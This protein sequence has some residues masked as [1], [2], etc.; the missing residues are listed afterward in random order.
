MPEPG[1]VGTVALLEVREDCCV[2]TRRAR[3]LLPRPR[4]RAAPLLVGSFAEPRVRA[5]SQVA[6]PGG[7][8]TTAEDHGQRGAAAG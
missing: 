1:L 8:V 3:L 2:G 5:Q 7:L 4:T 6:A